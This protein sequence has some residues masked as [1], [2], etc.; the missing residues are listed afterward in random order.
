MQRGFDF[1]DSSKPEKG[2]FVNKQKY[3]TKVLDLGQDRWYPI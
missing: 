3:F 2:L 1:K